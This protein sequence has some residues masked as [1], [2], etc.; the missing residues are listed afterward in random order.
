MTSPLTAAERELR[1]AD[2]KA[3]RR[4][5]ARS[6]MAD[7]AARAAAFNANRERLKSA[8]LTREARLKVKK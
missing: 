3:A 7:R 6:A 2:D 8:R 1:A 5:D 4:A